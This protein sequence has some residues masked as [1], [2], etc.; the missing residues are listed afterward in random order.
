MK[1][2]NIYR[3][4][5][6]SA[7]FILLIIILVCIMDYK[8]NHEY[9]EEKFLYFYDCNDTVCVSSAMDNSKTII[10]KYECRYT[11][12]PKYERIINNDYALL[13]ESD[14]SY[15]L[16][17]YKSG[18][19]ISAGYNNYS[20]IDDEYIVVTKNNKDGII[21]INDEIVVDTIY[22]KLGIIDNDNLTGYNKDYIIALKNDKYGIISIKDG[23]IREDFKYDKDKLDELLVLISN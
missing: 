6:V 9:E 13:K 10:S 23:K 12:C 5:W 2:K 14:N 11:E 15:E 3:I 1:N 21:N 18:N 19:I 8:I 22:D 20:F 7:L 16:Y 4:I 17:N